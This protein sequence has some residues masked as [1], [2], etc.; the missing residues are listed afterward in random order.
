MSCID[1]AETASS[2]ELLPA[3]VAVVPSPLPHFTPEL[4]SS[5]NGSRRICR[6]NH[7]SLKW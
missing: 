3:E 6:S 5:I 2:Q 1:S 7:I 4:P